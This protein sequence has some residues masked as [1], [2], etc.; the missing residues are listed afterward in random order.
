MEEHNGQ[1]NLF[2]D[3]TDTFE[4]GDQFVDGDGNVYTIV[5]LFAASI[6]GWLLVKRNRINKWTEA[7]WLTRKNQTTDW[8]RELAKPIAQLHLTKLENKNGN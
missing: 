1:L 2:G 5:S 8:Q 7:V 6:Q 3:D 4:V